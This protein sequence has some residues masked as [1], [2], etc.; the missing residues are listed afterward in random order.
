V[1]IAMGAWSLVYRQRT[2]S[3]F[4][5]DLEGTTCSGLERDEQATCHTAL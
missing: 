1:D 5:K 3:V 2:W 4:W